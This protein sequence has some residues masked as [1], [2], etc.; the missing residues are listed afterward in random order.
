M[1]IKAVRTFIESVLIYGI[2]SKFQT[3]EIKALPQN[4]PK[5]HKELEKVFGDGNQEQ[6]DDF[7]DE[8]D[9]EYHS[10]VSF[11]LNVVGLS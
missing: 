4:I 3:F 2:K 6:D 5:I 8:G 11:K 9:D 7:G 1:H 10:Y